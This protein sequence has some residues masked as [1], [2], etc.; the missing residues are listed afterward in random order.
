MLRR[1][2]ED[3][4]RR[5]CTAATCNDD[6]RSRFVGTMLMAML[7]LVTIMDMRL[8]DSNQHQDGG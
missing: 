2:N 1:G 3:A 6:S 8:M 7:L 4:R 5:T